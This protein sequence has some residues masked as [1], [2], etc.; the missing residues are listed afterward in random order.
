MPTTAEK[1]NLLAFTFDSLYFCGTPVE[2]LSGPRLKAA[3]NEWYMPLI[4]AGWAVPLAFILDVSTLLLQPWM[5][6]KNRWKE[7]HPEE[8]RRLSRDY[9]QMLQK[10]R[11]Q[12]VFAAVVELLD[13]TADEKRR[14]QAVKTFLRF[15]LS[16]LGQFRDTYAF[17][18]RDLKLEQARPAAGRIAGLVVRLAGKMMQ[19]DVVFDDVARRQ[20]RNEFGTIVDMMR[21]ITRQY[22]QRDL[23]EIFSEEERLMV[24][25]AARSPAGIA[26]I[27]YRF[28]QELLSS[29]GLSDVDEIEP[30]PRME[31]KLIPTDSYEVD[32][33]VGGYIDVNRRRFSG[34]V[35]EILPGEL[36]LCRHPAIMFHKLLNEGALHFV[37]ENIECIEEELRVLFCFVIDVEDRMLRAPADAHPA[38]GAGITPYIRARAVAARLIE[39]VVRFFPRKKVRLDLGLYLWSGKGGRIYRVE[40]DPFAAWTPAEAGNRFRFVAGLAARAPH[41]F[42]NRL[43]PDAAKEN[44][45]LDDDPA[46]YL[47]RRNESRRYHGRHLVLLSSTHTAEHVVPQRDPGLLAASHTGDSIFLIACDVNRLSLGILCPQTVQAAR[48]EQ[49]ARNYGQISE[50][51]LRARFLRHVL[52]KAAGKTV[53]TEALDSLSDLS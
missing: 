53:D 12:P 20:K 21:A 47:L 51:R 49:S 4:R 50:E 35:A 44:I 5:G 42:F 28:L 33:P 39:D 2:S 36:A 22:S 30:R 16:E 40:F 6:F 32:G 13:Q 8:I 41:L 27:D 38:L 17:D 43:G 19:G 29:R 46:Q 18:T 7:D 14:N 31:E 48:D 34:G 15:F 25:I 1:V 23:S 45:A 9:Y 37:R 26:R 52:M 10:L 24:E 3:V 11:R